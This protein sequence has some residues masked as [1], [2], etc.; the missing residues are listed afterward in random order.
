MGINIISER[1][2][3]PQH[4]KNLQ[5]TYKALLSDHIVVTKVTFRTPSS[6]MCSSWRC[7]ARLWN[8]PFVP[9]MWSLN[10]A[11]VLQILESAGDIRL[12]L[13][14]FGFQP[15]VSAPDTFRDVCIGKIALHSIFGYLRFHIS[16]WQ[17]LPNLMIQMPLYH[18][19]FVLWKTQTGRRLHHL[20][21]FILQSGKRN[22]T[23]CTHIASCFYLEPGLTSQ[24]LIVG[25]GPFLHNA[26]TV[27]MHLTVSGNAIKTI[28]LSYAFCQTSSGSCEHIHISWAD[29]YLNLWAYDENWHTI[30][31]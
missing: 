14:V 4:T 20:P 7:N 10:K 29:V 13:N 28:S 21:T 25:G 22:Q 9:M 19:M 2:V 15:V 6:S 17:R 16:Q 23:I 8:I 1:E 26:F 30:W 18:P 24:K 5:N 27:G 11:S 12:A 3:C 31:I